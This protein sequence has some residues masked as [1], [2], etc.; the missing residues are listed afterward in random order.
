MVLGKLSVPGIL[1]IWK[2]LGQG[3]AELAVNALGGVD[4]GGGCLHLLFLSIISLFFLPLC[5]R[6][7]DID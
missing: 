5:R 2:L 3:P 1:H 7:P 6:R 4:G